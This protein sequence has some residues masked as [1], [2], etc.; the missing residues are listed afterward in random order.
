VVIKS[1]PS[2]VLPGREGEF[3]LQQGGFPFWS[4]Q[5][6]GLTEWRVESPEMFP[7]FP[8]EPLSHLTRPS[9]KENVVMTPGKS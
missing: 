7:C 3:G 4:Y 8:D 5:G 2:V 1:V 9:P 6:G